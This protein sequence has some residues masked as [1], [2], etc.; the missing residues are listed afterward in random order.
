[1][2]SIAFPV[3]MRARFTVVEVQALACLA[4]GNEMEQAEA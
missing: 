4:V 2:K 1:L 3:K